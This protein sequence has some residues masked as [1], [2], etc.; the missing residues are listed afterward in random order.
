MH[1]QDNG[2]QQFLGT[3]MA[4]R[5]AGYEEAWQLEKVLMAGEKSPR[6]LTRSCG[7]DLKAHFQELEREQTSPQGSPT[8][9]AKCCAF[10]MNEYNKDPAAAEYESVLQYAIEASIAAAVQDSLLA[11]ERELFGLSDE[12]DVCDVAAS[13]VPYKKRRCAYTLPHAPLPPVLE[14]VEIPDSPPYCPSS[15]PSATLCITARP[16]TPAIVKP[17]IPLIADLDKHEPPSLHDLFCEESMPPPSPVVSEL[18]L[19]SPMSLDNDNNHDEP[20]LIQLLE[21]VTYL[22]NCHNLLALA[23]GYYAC[24]PSAQLALDTA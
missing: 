19:P 11:R 18:S 2:G 16:A 12:E 17:S 7:T 21:G 1:Q 9:V 20:P 5:G 24:S 3:V 6:P 4:H 10:I 23:T 13:P 15:P 14:I 8:T 22:P